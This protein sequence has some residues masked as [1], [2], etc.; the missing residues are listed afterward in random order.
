MACG[1]RAAGPRGRSGAGEGGKLVPKRRRVARALEG[2]H[3]G[4]VRALPLA[5]LEGITW[6]VYGIAVS[7]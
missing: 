3:H 4:R 7:C 6:E 5:A 2:F 1:G